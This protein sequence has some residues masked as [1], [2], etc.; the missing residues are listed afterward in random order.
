MKYVVLPC[1]QPVTLRIVYIPVE[2][3]MAAKELVPKAVQKVFSIS[4]CHHH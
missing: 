1:P 2:V 3:T 4:V